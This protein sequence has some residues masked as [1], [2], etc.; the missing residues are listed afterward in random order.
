MNLLEKVFEKVTGKIIEEEAPKFYSETDKPKGQATIVQDEPL[1]VF[2]NEE[3]VTP[4]E[5]PS[6]D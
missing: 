2:E 1:S 3:Y 5:R 4:S 6:F